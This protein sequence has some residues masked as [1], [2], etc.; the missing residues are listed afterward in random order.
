MIQVRTSQEITQ[1]LAR[2]TEAQ[3]RDDPG[4]CPVYSGDT[5]LTCL[6]CT[7]RDA[8]IWMLGGKTHT[9]S[10]KNVESY[11]EFFCKI[12]GENALRG[13]KAVPGGVTSYKV[14]SKFYN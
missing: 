5:S 11:E 6:E 12:C 9:S 14:C 7:C 4:L 8:F 3:R 2:C 13:Y 1:A 10:A